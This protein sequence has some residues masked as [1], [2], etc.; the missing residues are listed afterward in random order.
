MNDWQALNAEWKQI[1][2]APR[3]L[4]SICPNRDTLGE[5]YTLTDCRGCMMNTWPRFL[6]RFWLWRRE[7]LSRKAG[8]R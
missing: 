8:L 5:C 7:R 1:M 4:K 3:W 6:W 2:D